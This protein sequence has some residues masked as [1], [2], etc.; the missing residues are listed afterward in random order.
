MN[1]VFSIGLI[2]HFSAQN[3]ARAIRSHFQLP[4]PGGIAIIS[5]PTPT[6]LYRI[7]RFLSEMLGLWIFHDERP[8]KKSE[9]AGVIAH[10]GTLL[11][12]KTIWPI[13]L[14]QCIMVARKGGGT[15]AK[16]AAG[17]G[18]APPLAAPWSL[19]IVSRY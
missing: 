4:D 17:Y 11:Y 6:F 1:L 16:M 14:T 15:A 12:E 7:T 10:F 19:D 3:T 5:F 9:V 8:L 2:E 18:T 13:F